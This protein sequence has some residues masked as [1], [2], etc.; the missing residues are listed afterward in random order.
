MTIKG[1]NAIVTGSTSGIGLAIARGFA[2]RGANVVINGLGDAA[3]IERERA[4]IETEFGVRAVYSPANMLKADEIAAMV[5]DAEAGLGSVDILVNNAGIQH[6]APIEDFPI[7]KWDQIIAIN[8]SAA[9]HAIRAA[10]PG[11]K[12]RRWVASSTPRR[13][14]PPWPRRS[15]PPT[16][17][18]STA[19]WASPGRWRWRWRP[20]ASP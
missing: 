11:M 9:F 15:S 6:V 20:S 12:A 7:E 17:R 13:P 18:P 14:T 3:A 19:S 4:A 5:A 16:S 8:L 10:V 2:R 1:R